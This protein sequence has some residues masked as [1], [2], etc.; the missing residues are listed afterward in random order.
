MI[1][2]MMN[3]MMNIMTIKQINSMT[4]TMNNIMINLND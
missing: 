1:H 2:I 4:S 3:E